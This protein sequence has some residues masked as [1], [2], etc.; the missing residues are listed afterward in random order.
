MA[1]IKNSSV[2]QFIKSP[3]SHICIFLLHGP[4]VGLSYQRSE[5]IASQF[6]K[7][8]KEPANKIM[9]DS[10]DIEPDTAYLINL[11]QPDFFN[12]SDTVVR[13][14]LGSRNIAKILQY[15]IDNRNDNSIIIV[16]AEE[17]SKSSPIKKLIESHQN[18]AAIC[19]Y[20]DDRSFIAKSIDSFLLKNQVNIDDVSKK[21]LVN[22]LSG[23]RMILQSELDKVISFSSSTKLIAISDIEYL[24]ED[25]SLFN[26]QN[27]I[28]DALCGNRSS[29]EK[30]FIKIEMLAIDPNVLCIMLL[31]YLIQLSDI[32]HMRNIEL[33][34]FEEI[35]RKKNIH[36]SRSEHVSKQIKIWKETEILF[37][38]KYTNT[39]ISLIRKNSTIKNEICNR[40]FLKIASITTRK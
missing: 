3:P 30:S 19:N 35:V 4:N 7:D 33:L 10:D 28:D 14:R 8:S 13:I 27:I 36:F 23:D 39:Q 38:I 25:S 34:P 18:C 15:Y 21:Y 16:T 2:E 5:I 20:M 6:M 17:L 22:N 32:L 11:I 12:K 26:L 24:V 9:I 40:L 29:L 31:N 37:L 1:I